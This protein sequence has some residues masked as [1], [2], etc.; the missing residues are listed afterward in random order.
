MKP[1]FTSFDDGLDE[2][3]NDIGEVIDEEELQYLKELKELKKNYREAYKALKESKSETS[4]SQ[5]AIDSLK[6][7]LINTF[8]EWYSDTFEEE[9]KKEDMQKSS[10]KFASSGRGAINASALSGQKPTP[11]KL[12]RDPEMD[13]D[14]EDDGPQ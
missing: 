12:I 4:F 8:E 14:M 13:E 5:Q 10:T 11:G 9:E 3:P 6:Q 1:G 7:K 2:A